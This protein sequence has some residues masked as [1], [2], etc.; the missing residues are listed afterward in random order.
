MY[1]VPVIYDRWMMKK[2][3]ENMQAAIS[4]VLQFQRLKIIIDYQ[5]MSIIIP[6]NLIVLQVLKSRCIIFFILSVTKSTY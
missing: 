4:Q 5:V 6:R 3:S 1:W 2:A